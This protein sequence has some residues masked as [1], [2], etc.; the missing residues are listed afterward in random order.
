M[1]WIKEMQNAIEFI[2][3]RLFESL[4]I[5]DV[6]KSANSSPANFQRIFSIVT[7]MTAGD[8]IRVRR[9]SL[10]AQE[11]ISSEGNILET[12]MKYGYE[13]AAGFT[14]AFTRFHGATPSD[15]MR[16]NAGATYFAPLSINLDIQG[17]ISKMKYPTEWQT[18]EI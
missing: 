5:E 13:S 17:G 7:G 18:S 8:Y 16:R 6:A 1:Y 15:V 9:L 3:G 14:K 2:E 4:V 11:L 12:A 10:A